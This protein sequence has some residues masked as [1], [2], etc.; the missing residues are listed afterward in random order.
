MSLSNGAMAAMFKMRFSLWSREAVQKLI[1]ERFDV[2]FGRHHVGRLLN[3]WG[4]TPQRPIKKAYE[5]RPAEVKRWMQETYPKV[6]A[7]ANEENAEIWWGDETAVKPECHYR[8]SYSP[9]GKTPIVRQPAKRFHSSWISA[10]NNQGK[11][12]WMPL[13]E[14][15]HAQ[16][17]ITF[18]K[19]LAKHRKRKMILILDNLRVRHSKLVTAWVAENK[20]RIERVHLPTYSPELNPDECLNN[21]QKQTVTKEG[22]STSESELDFKK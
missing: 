4:F 6:Q 18:L 11:M 10:V 16:S 9:K 1:E 19:Q 14:P 21:H 15:L 13:K 2:R 20:Q 17:F 8:R 5:Q 12:Q 22:P 3:R 7:K